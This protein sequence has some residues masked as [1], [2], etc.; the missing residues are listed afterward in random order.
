MRTYVVFRMDSFLWVYCEFIS[1][2]SLLG[3]LLGHN[4]STLW[5]RDHCGLSLKF[6]PAGT[7]SLMGFVCIGLIFLTHQGGAHSHTEQYRGLIGRFVFADAARRGQ[8]W[9]EWA[10]GLKITDL[11]RVPRPV[12]HFSKFVISWPW[13]FLRDVGRRGHRGWGWFNLDPGQR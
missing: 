4:F 9:K 8:G 5:N 11:S 7:C 1:C 2:R 10:L 6:P 13:L 12:L 3:G